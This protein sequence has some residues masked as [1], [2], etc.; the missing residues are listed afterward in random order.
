MVDSLLRIQ[1][2][3]LRRNLTFDKRLTFSI[4][5]LAFYLRIKAQQR[6]LVSAEEIE[7]A[8]K[9]SFNNMQGHG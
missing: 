6:G 3:A 1:P 4:E 5:P 2:A 9:R 7:S 8:T